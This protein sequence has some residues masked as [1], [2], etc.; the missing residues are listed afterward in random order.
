MPE[1]I[2][3]K[4]YMHHFRSSGEGTPEKIFSSPELVKKAHLKAIP[5]GRSSL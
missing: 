3:N 2:A 5:G 4:L 1:I